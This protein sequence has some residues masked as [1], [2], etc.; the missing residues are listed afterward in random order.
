[1][2]PDDNK[3]DLSVDLQGKLSAISDLLDRS[4]EQLNQDTLTALSRARAHAVQ[5]ARDTAR[6][7]ANRKPVWQGWLWPTGGL[8]TAVAVALTVIMLSSGPVNLNGELGAPEFE[9]LASNDTLEVVE[10]LEFY[11]WL[12]DAALDDPGES[13]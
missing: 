3:P 2:K 10:D 13:G 8:A 1:M 9:L 12:T 5:G 6:R 7:K 4:V 11:Q